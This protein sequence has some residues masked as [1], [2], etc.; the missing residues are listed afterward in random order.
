[1]L[2]LRYSGLNAVDVFESVSGEYGQFEEGASNV[3]GDDEGVPVPLLA[4]SITPEQ[5]TLIRDTV[6]PI[7]DDDQHG[8]SLYRSVIDNP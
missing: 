3:E 4:L 5:M 8:L 2:T 7:S 6:N 1:M